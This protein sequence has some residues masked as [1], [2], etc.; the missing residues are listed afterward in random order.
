MRESI[1]VGYRERVEIVQA[2]D[3]FCRLSGVSRSAFL[4]LALRR[5]LNEK[6]KTPTGGKEPVS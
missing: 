4:R 6:M 1:F 2:L 3:E 5:L